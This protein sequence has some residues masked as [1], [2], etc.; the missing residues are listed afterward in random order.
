MAACHSALVNSCACN[1]RSRQPRPRC[2]LMMWT[3][4][5]IGFNVHLDRRAIF[6]AEK[7]CCARQLGGAAK[8]ER[9]ATKNGVAVVLI[10]PS[11]RGMKMAMPAKLLG[12]HPSLID[13]GGT[14]SPEI[15]LLQRDDIDRQLG[16][17]LGDARFRTLPIHSRRSHAHCR[18]RRE[19]SV[20]T[21]GSFVTFACVADNY[22]CDRKI[23]MARPL[24]FSFQ[25]RLCQSS[26]VTSCEWILSSSKTF[27][28]GRDELPVEH[29]QVRLFV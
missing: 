23:D 1:K 17:H 22:I 2:V 25:G 20:R 5:E 11:H 13:A 12:D 10:V 7:R 8:R 16:D 28:Y 3:V 6:P 26:R 29:V 18:W 21:F 14:S 24:I 19:A 15:E 27:A 4:A 9:V